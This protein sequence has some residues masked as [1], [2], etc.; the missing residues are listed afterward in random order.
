MTATLVDAHCHLDL[1]RDYSG[2]IRG[3]REAGVTTVAVTTTPS[4]IRRYQQIIA[5][6]PSI[7]VAAGLHP[8]LVASRASELPLLL[9]LVPDFRFIGEVGLDFTDPDRDRQRKQVVAFEAILR[10]CA[11]VGG[12]VLSVHSRRAVGAVLSSIGPGFASDVI[13][14]WFA[15]TKV[16]L[17]RATEMGCY[18]SVNPAMLRSEKGRTLVRAMEPSRVLTESDGPFVEVDGRPATPLDMAGVVRELGGL[19]G[20]SE[21]A[22]RER[23]WSTHLSL[24]GLP[25]AAQP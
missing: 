5:G 13:L 21:E 22:A 25:R 10:R 19:W 23:I 17:Q 16:E 2:V 8:E 3:V 24:T 11:E 7:T 4:V 1:Y 9:S 6:C 12:R 20:T 15:G 14:H 18:F